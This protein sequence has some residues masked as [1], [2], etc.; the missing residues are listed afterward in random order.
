MFFI[1][2]LYFNLFCRYLFEDIY[3]KK[4]WKF[5][6]EIFKKLIVSILYDRIVLVLLL[7]LLEYFLV[8]GS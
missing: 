8:I 2:F 7:L 5:F 4:F 3:C 6:L 1:F